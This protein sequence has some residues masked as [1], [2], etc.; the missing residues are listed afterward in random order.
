MLSNLCVFVAFDNKHVDPLENSAD[1]DVKD[2]Q[3]GDGM[4]IY[5]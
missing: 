2:P 4:Y 3:S 5:I 1:N